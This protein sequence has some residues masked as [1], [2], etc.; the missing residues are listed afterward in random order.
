MVRL[1]IE[2][3]MYYI[4]SE[5]DAR[6]LFVLQYIFLPCQT[7]CD[8]FDGRMTKRPRGRPELDPATVKRKTV[9]V[10][11][12]ETEFNLLN[13]KASKSGLRL[14]EFVRGRLLKG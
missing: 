1:L 10:R 13:K 5:G 14:S 7:R 3:I 9:Q 11:F 12:T 4:K 2:Y 8:T 6:T